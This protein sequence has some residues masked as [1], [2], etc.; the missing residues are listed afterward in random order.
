MEVCSNA[1]LSNVETFDERPLDQ[2]DPELAAQM[3]SGSQ[4]RRTLHLPQQHAC[5]ETRE[6]KHALTRGA[7][8]RLPC[9][10]SCVWLKRGHRVLFGAYWNGKGYDHE[11]R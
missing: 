3:V 4:R 10:A 11:D 2:I 1:R 7:H 5:S 9:V 8:R 6:R